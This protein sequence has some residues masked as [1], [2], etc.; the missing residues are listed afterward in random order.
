M[1]IALTHTPSNA[2]GQCALT[3]LQRIP[4]DGELAKQQHR[5]YLATLHDMEV[6]VRNHEFN[7]AQPDG[8]FVEDVAVVFDECIVL[9]AM[10]TASRQAETESWAK[11]LQSFGRVLRL[12]RGAT[13]EGGDVLRLNKDLLVG[14]S[15]RTN[16]AAIEALSL[17]VTPMG[18]RVHPIE[19]LGCLHL[20]TACTALDHDCLLVNSDWIRT[21]KLPKRKMIEAVE[22]WGANV[23]RLPNGRLLMSSTHQRTHEELDAAGFSLTLVELSE[24]EKAEAGITCLS[25]VIG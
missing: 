22:P 7:A 8:C 17:L 24:F 19:V 14:L 1:A 9:G 15:S 23:L 4:I 2:L 21:D 18:Y 11:V 16:A 10:G 12:P 20:K 6:D 5:A 13:L 25:I 3:H